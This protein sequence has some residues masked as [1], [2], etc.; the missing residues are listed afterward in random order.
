MLYEQGRLCLFLNIPSLQLTHPFQRET[1]NN[2]MVL[3]DLKEVGYN[4]YE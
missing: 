1:E 2:L 3:K 4:C